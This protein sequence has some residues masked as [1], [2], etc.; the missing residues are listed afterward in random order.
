MAATTKT[1]KPMTT[2]DHAQ[3]LSRLVSDP[4]RRNRYLDKLLAES[5][6]VLAELLRWEKPYRP[7][8]VP[9]SGAD[10]LMESAHRQALKWR[11]DAEKAKAQAERDAAL[12]ADLGYRAEAAPRQRS[13]PRAAT[14]G[15][16]DDETAKLRAAL[17][18]AKS[19]H[20]TDEDGEDDFDFGPSPTPE[21][22]GH[23]KAA[24]PPI[25]EDGFWNAR[26]ELQHARDF[27]RSRRVSPW[28]MLAEELLRVV[29]ATP[30]EV[31]LPALVG[32]YGSLNLFAA[33]VGAP[34]AGKG[35]SASAASDA[36]R[37][38]ST[39]PVETAGVGSGEGI[40]H[41]LAH[42]E[43]GQLVRDR[44]AVLL[45]AAE[46]DSLAALGK[47]RTGATLLPELR[48]AWSGEALGFGYADAKKRLLIDA[49]S[50]RLALSVGV[51][52][53]RAEAL[54]DDA[55]AG[56]PQRF[57]WVPTTD[58]GAPDHPLVEP[59]PLD[60]MVKLEPE[61]LR[62]RSLQQRRI[63]QV[64]REAKEAIQT[65]R[66]ARLRG[67]DDAAAQADQHALYAR[68]KVAAAMALLADRLKITAE[69]WT[70]AGTFMAISDRTRGEVVTHLNAEK[71]RANRA[72]GVSDGERAAVA[73]ATADAYEEG[74]QR[75]VQWLR[76]WSKWGDGPHTLGMVR[77]AAPSRL[78]EYVESALAALVR[79]CDVE[80]DE[81]DRYSWLGR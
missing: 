19:S 77:K 24:S 12:R 56:M 62:L 72:R 38:P 66:L 8:G 4:P 44:T 79:T 47:G 43:K 41:L 78:R 37:I 60:V 31:V 2:L 81:D 67:G 5:P 13:K 40:G 35:A 55:D 73:K 25:D 70:L 16:E 21:G 30:P 28:S 18:A 68:L 63:M 46:V 10:R 48:K 15:T 71:S 27:A 23:S 51:Q 57:I 34:G 11:A 29:T 32:G 45:T 74:V 22:S 1:G 6:E 80:C 64:P 61:F 33:I 20:A 14:A 59:E 58:P 76:S 7:P 49:H 53:G 65:A 69:D 52:P 42:T 36:V 26:P 17:L 3:E 54:L 50:Y 9:K 39:L 75:A